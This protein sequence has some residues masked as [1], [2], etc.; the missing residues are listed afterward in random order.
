[1]SDL[2]IH[3]SGEIVSAETA[4]SA[5]A[6]TAKA[7]VEARFTVALK[8]PRDWDAVRQNLIKEC[9][10]PSFAHDKS[11]LYKKPIGS[12]VE[13]LGIRFVETALRCMKNVHI[14]AAT[15][16]E[17]DQKRILTVS[18]TDLES[19]ITYDK[20]VTV[21]KTV[22]R[23]KPNSDGSYLTKRKNT[24][25]RDV[26]L[27]SATDDDLLNKEG[28]MVSKAIRTSGLR[29]VPG[30]LQSECEA[31][32]RKIRVD[33]A[34]KDPDAEKRSIADA[35]ADLNVSVAMLQE[36]LGHKLETCSPAE[37]VDLRGIYGSIKDGE[38][39]WQAIMDEKK[40]KASIE[41]LKGKQPEPEPEKPKRSRKTTE[42]V[43]PPPVEATSSDTLQMT[44][45]EWMTKFSKAATEDAIDELEA[46]IGLLAAHVQGLAKDQLEELKQQAKASRS[47][48]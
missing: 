18:V 4:G 25:G 38:L 41:D 35:F 33:K 7:L 42:A 27:V 48:E 13:G 9:E 44:L 5:A 32:I 6:S 39:T 22:E 21:T 30:D 24:Q 11:T 26:F 34:A 28:S 1:M 23:S 10:R 8:F 29:L 31:I 36:F 20:S 46:D 15:T 40:P 2:T 14:N 19:N 47:M 12:G 45:D 17:D 43:A 3:S 37:L 16:Y